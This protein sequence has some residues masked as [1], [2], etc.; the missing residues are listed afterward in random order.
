MT[1]PSHS[2]V[3]TNEEV[4]SSVQLLDGACCNYWT[5]NLFLS[6]NFVQN[7]ER[8]CLP[9]S[10][11]ISYCSS[12]IWIS[13]IVVSAYPTHLKSL[14]K[15]SDSLSIFCHYFSHY[16]LRWHSM[17]L[18][19]PSHHASCRVP[20]LYPSCSYLH[21]SALMRSAHGY[22]FFA[23]HHWVEYLL[24]NTQGAI[25]QGWMPGAS[26]GQ[27]EVHNFFCPSLSWVFCCSILAAT[28]ASNISA[29]CLEKQWLIQKLKY[30]TFQNPF[31]L[32]RQITSLGGWGIHHHQSRHNF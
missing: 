7:F 29:P 14:S 27:E 11:I 16:L 15:S 12:Q 21:C 1:S 25:V 5:E 13:P 3:C 23:T 17:Y 32:L 28:L 26:L 31:P 19:L 2:E 20:L 9:S 8:R 24:P 22:I 10:K 4:S 30:H 6:Q 18:C